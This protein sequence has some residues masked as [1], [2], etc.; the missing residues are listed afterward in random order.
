MD[1][2]F[3]AMS[4]VVKNLENH[5]MEYNSDLTEVKD[6]CIRLRGDKERYE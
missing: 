5:S 4:E 3:K 2:N 1:Q 6:E